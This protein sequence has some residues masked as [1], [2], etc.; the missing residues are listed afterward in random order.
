MANSPALNAQPPHWADV[1]DAAGIV[2]ACGH[3]TL[4]ERL[5]AFSERLEPKR[6][7]LHIAMCQAVALLNRSPEVARCSEGRE[8][9]DILRNALT[10]FA[11]KYGA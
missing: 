7:G 10:A 6:D 2:R 3:A 9:R 1:A 11:E 4:A 5:L 8:A